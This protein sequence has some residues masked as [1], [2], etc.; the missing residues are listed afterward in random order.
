[1]RMKARIHY[2]HLY[3]P[4]QGGRSSREASL[5]P[6]RGKVRMGGTFEA[7]TFIVVTY[8]AMSKNDKSRSPLGFLLLI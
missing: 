6:T 8:N 4:P 1:M 5:P 2:P 7:M 3:P